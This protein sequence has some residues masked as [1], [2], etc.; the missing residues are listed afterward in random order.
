METC[1]N[2]AGVVACPVLV[3]VQS[4]GQLLG[5]VAGREVDHPLVPPV[6][7]K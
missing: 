1:D 2:M 4:Y 5:P 6:L 3:A 7:L